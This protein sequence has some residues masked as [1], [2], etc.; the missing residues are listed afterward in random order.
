MAPKK[1]EVIGHNQPVGPVSSIFSGMG[2]T[3]AEITAVKSQGFVTAELRGQTCTVYKMRFRIAGRQ[4]VL[5][6]GTDPLVAD[7]VREELQRLQKSRHTRRNMQ[8][9]IRQA[10]RLLRDSKSELLADA[11][12]EGYRFHGLALRRPR[13]PAPTNSVPITF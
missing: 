11:K 8:A 12:Q 6:L 2:L 7:A 1:Q 13:R 4:R 10:N 9:L 5:Y 3:P